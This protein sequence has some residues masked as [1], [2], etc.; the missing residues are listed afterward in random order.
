MKGKIYLVP[1]PIGNL[2]DITLRAIK[3]LNEVDLIAA[4]DTRHT[5]KLLNHFN[6]KKPLIS[7]YKQNEKIKTN[8]LIDKALKGEK[9]AIVS[10]AGTPII[11]DPGQEIVNKAIEEGIQVIPLPG[12]C[13]A[14]SALI[15]SG[16]NSKEFCFI[17]FLPKNKKEIKEKLEEIKEYNQTIIFY[18]APHRI[19][20]T[21]KNILEILG[22]R[23]IC[24]ARE[25]TKIY[26]E[27]NKNKITKILKEIEE[28]KGE[29]VIILE[30]S[31]DNKKDNNKKILN[32]LTLE[33][34]Y[35]YYEELGIDKKEIIKKIA[36]DR[37]TNKNEIYKYF[38]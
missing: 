36:Q 1:T 10:D 18:E 2:E 29:Y 32:E 4:E 16:I 13:A 20:N 28:P 17:G 6:I 34:H 24:I 7:Y 8:I 33:K 14:I 5:L 26:E 27:F 9:I 30:G 35:K 3:T 25:I 38:I 37:E 12:P 19:K 23:N 21:L 15:A 22:D 11:S 31:K